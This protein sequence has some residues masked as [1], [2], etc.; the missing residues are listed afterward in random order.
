MHCSIYIDLPSLVQ[1]YSRHLC[2]S[3][4]GLNLPLVYMYCSIYVYTSAK[5]GVVVLNAY[6][7]D[8]KGGNLP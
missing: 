2:L 7:L 5:F 3:D 8:C 6:M 1:Q 4:W